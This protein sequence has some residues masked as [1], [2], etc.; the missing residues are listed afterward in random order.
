ME[1]FCADGNEPSGYNKGGEFVTEELLASQEELC[2][3]EIS[4]NPSSN[5]LRRRL[6]PGDGEKKISPSIGF[7]PTTVGNVTELLCTPD[8]T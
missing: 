7:E 6:A 8:T 1:C 3:M 4:R 2:S 5:S